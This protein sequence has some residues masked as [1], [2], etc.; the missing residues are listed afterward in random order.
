MV[1]Y[2][3]RYDITTEHTDARH[4][5]VIAP[6]HR[7]YSGAEK[8][9]AAPWFGRPDEVFCFLWFYGLLLQLDFTYIGR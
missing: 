7:L 1:A 8:T 6:E 4:A 2:R 3:I 9:Q 5:S